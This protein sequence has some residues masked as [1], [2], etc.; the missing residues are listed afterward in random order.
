MDR[1][2]QDPLAGNWRRPKVVPEVPAELDLVV[3]LTDGG[4]CGAVVGTEKGPGGHLVILEDGLGRRR[5]FPL[6]PGFLLEGKPV[7]LV[8]P[9]VAAPKRCGRDPSGRPPRA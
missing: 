5:M 8:T 7:T 9:V 4:F 3:E 2:A 1:Y 6:G